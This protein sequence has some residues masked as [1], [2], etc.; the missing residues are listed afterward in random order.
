[1]IAFLSTQLRSQAPDQYEFSIASSS[2]SIVSNLC[3]MATSF[4]SIFTLP[5]PFIP[6]HSWILDSGATNHICCNYSLFDHFEP[7]TSTSVTLPNGDSMIV[8]QMGSEKI[9]DQLILHQCSTFVLFILTWLASI[10][11]FLHL[12]I[13]L[14]FDQIL[15]SLRT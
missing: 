10:V 9:T 8:Q 12:L 13:L 6:Q 4:S 15:V 7:M 3:G 14:F 11:L 1:M 2:S 5:H